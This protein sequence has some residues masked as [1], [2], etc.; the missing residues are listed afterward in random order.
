L[1]DGVRF[2]KAKKTSFLS[3]PTAHELEGISQEAKRADEDVEEAE[4]QD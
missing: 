3:K 1:T 2:I 4:K